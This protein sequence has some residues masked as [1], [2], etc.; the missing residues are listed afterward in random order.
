[1]KR[2]RRPRTD[3]I[4]QTIKLM[5]DVVKGPPEPP[6]HVKLRPWDMPFWDAIIRQRARDDWTEVDLVV[7]AQLARTQADIETESALLETEGTIGTGGQKQDVVSP[8]LS[9][10]GLLCKREMAL[11]RTLRLGGVGNAANAA[12]R[13]RL[14]RQA[15]SLAAESVDSE[16]DRLLA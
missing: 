2:P 15:E 6:A 5:E 16:D 9:V 3:S 4:E 8:R 7:A 1:V 13:R 10:V 14:E 12:E 11:L